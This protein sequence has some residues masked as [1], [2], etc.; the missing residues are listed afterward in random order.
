MHVSEA[1]SGPS[2]STLLIASAAS[3]R[4][5]LHE[6]LASMREMGYIYAI[7]GQAGPREFFEKA[8]GA[9]A[10][11]EGWPKYDGGRMK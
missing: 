10:V 1:C 3:R 5:L 6:C 7:I 11:P 8:C 2:A 9:L 4:V